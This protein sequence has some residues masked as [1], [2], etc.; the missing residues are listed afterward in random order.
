MLAL[1]VTIDAL[2]FVVCLGLHAIDRTL[3]DIRDELRK[4]RGEQDGQT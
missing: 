4:M 2:I 3:E 1:V